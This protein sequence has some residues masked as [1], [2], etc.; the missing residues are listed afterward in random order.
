MIW[1][2]VG[3]KACASFPK[4]VALLRF[5]Q[6]W[7]ELLLGRGGWIDRAINLWEQS[8]SGQAIPAQAREAGHLAG[9]LRTC[10]SDATAVEAYRRASLLHVREKRDE[11][12][13]DYRAAA[14]SACPG[15]QELSRDGLR[16][17]GIGK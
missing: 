2:E 1:F 6:A 17:L 3:N 14:A 16:R 4:D 5:S 9:V 10:R 7:G 12:A 15:L 11:A 8:A 13:R